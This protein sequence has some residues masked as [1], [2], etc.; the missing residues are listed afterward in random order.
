MSQVFQNPEEYRSK[1]IPLASSYLTGPQYVDILGKHLAPNTF[2]YNQMPLEDYVKLPYPGATDMGNMY[3]YFDT[4]KQ[5]RDI[6]L[7]RKL[8]TNLIDFESWVMRN[9]EKLLKKFN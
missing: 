1:V 4:Q 7:T 9:Q 3:E 6:E 5:L 8:N 2:F